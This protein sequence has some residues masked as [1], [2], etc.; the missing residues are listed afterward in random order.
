MDYFQLQSLFYYQQKN[1]I[2]LHRNT[3]ALELKSL[4]RRL[5]YTPKTLLHPY[6]I[7]QD[8]LDKDKNISDDGITN[9]T[10]SI[11]SLNSE[12]EFNI[13]E[14]PITVIRR[15]YT[16]QMVDCE[17]NNKIM[18]ENCFNECQQEKFISNQTDGTNMLKN[19]TTLSETC[20]P[21]LDSQSKVSFVNPIKK[22]D[23]V[24]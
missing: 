4:S 5:K 7:S 6:R 19:D 8:R 14:K 21:I 18:V 11:E 16:K 2:K 15:H 9:N 12:V 17:K 22:I 23:I 13:M 24:I 20:N 1:N 3:N 10:M